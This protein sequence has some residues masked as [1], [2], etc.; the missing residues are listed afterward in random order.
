M[1]PFPSMVYFIYTKGKLLT[2]ASDSLY[3]WAWCMCAQYTEQ[4]TQRHLGTEFDRTFRD[5]TSNLDVD[6]MFSY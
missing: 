6:V 2:V 1:S 5:V 4:P 3:V